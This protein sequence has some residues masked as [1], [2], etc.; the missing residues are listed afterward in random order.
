VEEALY[1][2]AERNGL[3][4]DDGARQCWATIRGGISAG[5][6][7]PLDPDDKT[8]SPRREPS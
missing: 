5:L 1:G 7:D 6:Q 2:A 8:R 3:V 4:T